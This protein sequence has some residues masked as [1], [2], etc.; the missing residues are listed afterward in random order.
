[1]IVK[2][3]I[4][5]LNWCSINFI[6][7]GEVI[8]LI[9]DYSVEAVKTLF[10]SFKSNLLIKSNLFIPVSRGF[11]RTL[12]SGF[13]LPGNGGAATHDLG[14]HPNKNKNNQGLRVIASKESSEGRTIKGLHVLTLRV[15][16]PLRFP[17]F[18]R[19]EAVSV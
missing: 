8:H 2:F 4:V 16:Q 9:A 5:A 7:Y 3:H 1:M 18:V 12:V 14:I 17:F 10:P 19:D 15:L 13:S 11:L 6:H